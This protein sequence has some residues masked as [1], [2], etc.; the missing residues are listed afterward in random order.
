MH[1]EELLHTV[2]SPP[3][4]I[5]VNKFREMYHSHGDYKCVQNFDMK[6]GLKR[7][8]NKSEDVLWTLVLTVILKL[9]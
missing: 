6:E 9:K 7:R 1:G 8:Y 3:D 4:I 5:T 2:Y